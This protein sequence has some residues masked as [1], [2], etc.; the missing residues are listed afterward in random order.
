MTY[1]IYVLSYLEAV[2]PSPHL[3]TEGI[4][5]VQ[6]SSHG[7]NTA[8]NGED[9]MFMVQ[10]QLQNGEDKMFMVQIQLE[11]GEDKM[12]MVQVQLEMVKTKC[13]WFKYSWKW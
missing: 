4:C 7:S 2:Q 10:I 3:G 9:K 13:S 6:S 11:N 8:G 1:P 5:A 12:F